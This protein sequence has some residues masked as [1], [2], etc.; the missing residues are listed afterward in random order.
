VGPHLRVERLDT[1]G[2]IVGTQRSDRFQKLTS[3]AD[4]GDAKVLEVV[5]YEVGQQFGVDVI[6]PECR[7][8]SFKTEGFATSP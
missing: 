3:M 5:G 7:R 6:L 2:R 1:R 8:V 4:G